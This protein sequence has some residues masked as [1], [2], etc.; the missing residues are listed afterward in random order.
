VLIK[1]A[2]QNLTSSRLTI[3]DIGTKLVKINTHVPKFFTKNVPLEDYV[4]ILY[5]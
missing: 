4:S 5:K 3:R 2:Y 1:D